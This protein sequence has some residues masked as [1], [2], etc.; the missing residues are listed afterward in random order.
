[1]NA[2]TPARH[3]ETTERTRLLPAVV[4]ATDPTDGD[5]P[6]RHRLTAI[7]TRHHRD[8]PVVGLPTRVDGC[9]GA[10]GS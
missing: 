1:M 3:R 4:A 10:A 7:A 6:T 8:W 9:P 2:V 5:L